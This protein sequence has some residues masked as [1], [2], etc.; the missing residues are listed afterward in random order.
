VSPASPRE[1]RPL[2]AQ[3]DELAGCTPQ[4][5]ARR[6]ERQTKVLGPEKLALAGRAEQFDV[7]QSGK[8]PVVRRAH[9]LDADDV[10]QCLERRVSLEKPVRDVGLLELNGGPEEE[11]RLASAKRT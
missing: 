8:V 5:S 11:F 7:C 3:L 9:R 6:I 1:K 10:S 4:L 2:P